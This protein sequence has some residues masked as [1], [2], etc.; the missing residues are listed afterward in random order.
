MQ[1]VVQ[2]KIRVQVD[3]QKLPKAFTWHNRIYQIQKVIDAWK[4]VGEWWNNATPRTV[5]RVLTPQ[6]TYEIHYLQQP[7]CWILYAIYD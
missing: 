4:E 2:K 1:K 7:N 6:G 5:Y 3:E